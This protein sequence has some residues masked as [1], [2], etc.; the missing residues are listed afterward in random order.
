MMTQLMRLAAAAL[1][2]LLGGAATAQESDWAQGPLIMGDLNA[3]VKMVEYASM[4]CPHCAQFHAETL[5][6]LKEKYIDTGKVQLEFREFPF[7]GLALRASMLA[8]CAG[9]A[10]VFGMIDVLF[11]QQV[12]W[13]RAQD[14]IAE[15]GKLGKLGGVSESRFEACMQ[16][17]AL[18][19]AVLANRLEGEQ[20]MKVDS[21]P[22]FFI[23]GEKLS[24]AQPLADF[25]K[26]I[27][28][29]LP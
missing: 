20:K 15:L 10:R 19:D 27:D 2:L 4:T 3:P 16:N 24:G 7:D 29:H 11:K 22:T 6:P 5:K 9:P 8:R 26:A 23:N 28:K 1:L 25:E 18:A 17:Q 12:N 13:A 14:P 21:T